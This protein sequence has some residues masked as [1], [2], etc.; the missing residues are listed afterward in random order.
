M[1]QPKIIGRHPA[2]DRKNPGF[3]QPAKRPVGSGFF[4]NHREVIAAGNIT[5]RRL[6]ATPLRR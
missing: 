1:K 2:A 6:A 4:R 3:N 5:L